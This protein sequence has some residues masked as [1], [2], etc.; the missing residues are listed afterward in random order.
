MIHRLEQVITTVPAISLCNQKAT[1]RTSPTGVLPSKYK[2]RLSALRSPVSQQHKRRH[3][4]TLSMDKSTWRISI[5]V[6]LPRGGTLC[7]GNLFTVKEHWS[8]VLLWDPATSVSACA[9]ALPDVEP[10]SQLGM[11]CFEQR[12]EFDPRSTEIDMERVESSKD[13][14][15]NH[16]FAPFHAVA[17]EPNLYYLEPSG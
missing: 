4:D 1:N 2:P 10:W 14:T 3:L 6:V 16:T 11:R 8:R 7:F 13:P 12:W 9:S 17:R 5:E 15:F